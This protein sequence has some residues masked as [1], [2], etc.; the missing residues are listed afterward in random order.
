MVGRVFLCWAGRG[1]FR[2]SA[3]RNA[4]IWPLKPIKWLFTAS[5]YGQSR[6]MMGEYSRTLPI[7]NSDARSVTV[8]LS[9]YN[10]SQQS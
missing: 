7:K 8:E 1:T 4:A 3:P 9:D 2:D 10:C 6:Y 5:R